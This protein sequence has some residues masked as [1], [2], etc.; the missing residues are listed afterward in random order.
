MESYTCVSA[1][2]VCCRCANHL[3]KSYAHFIHRPEKM[4]K[5]P[6]IL[7]NL[8]V[9]VDSVAP[10]VISKAYFSPLPVSHFHGFIWLFSKLM[11]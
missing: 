1:S 3:N 4:A 7:G 11:H 9:T 2:T 5:L 10:D 8:D 6:V